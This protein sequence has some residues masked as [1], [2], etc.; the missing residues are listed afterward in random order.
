MVGGLSAVKQERLLSYKPHII[1][2]TAGRLWQLM[3]EGSEDVRSSYI[4]MWL[5]I[6]LGFGLSW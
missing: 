6:Y 3:S 4:Y 1:V 5:L 2:G